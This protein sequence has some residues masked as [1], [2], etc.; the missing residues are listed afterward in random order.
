MKKRTS[1]LLSLLLTL[2]M[3][4]GMLPFMSTPAPALAANMIDCYWRGAKFTNSS[5]AVL[6]DEDGYYLADGISSVDWTFEAEKEHAY[7]HVFASHLS[8]SEYSEN[9]RAYLFANE[10]CTVPFQTVPVS[11]NTYYVRFQ[12]LIHTSDENI[13]LYQRLNDSNTT[14]A[15][16]GCTTTFVNSRHIRHWDIKDVENRVTDIYWVYELTFRVTQGYTLE[17]VTASAAGVLMDTTGKVRLKEYQYDLTWKAGYAPSYVGYVYPYLHTDPE[18]TQ[19]LSKM[20]E[21]DG[22]YYVPLTFYNTQANDTTINF[23]LISQATLNIPDFSVSKKSIRTFRYLSQD[24]VEILFEVQRDPYVIEKVEAN[25]KQ[26]KKD[27]QGKYYFSYCAATLTWKDDNS[28]SY[29]FNGDAYLYRDEECLN[30]PFLMELRPN[31]S[32]YA[33][34]V[35]RNAVAGNHGIDFSQISPD[36]TLS[37]LPGYTATFVKSVPYLGTDGMDAVRVIFRVTRGDEYILRRIDATSTGVKKH[38]DG[39]PYLDGLSYT[40]TWKDNKSPAL[41]GDDYGAPRFYT[42]A[43]CTNQVTTDLTV[44]TNYYVPLTFY[45]PVEYDHS[46]DFSQIGSLSTLTIP[47]C[48]AA[49]YKIIPFVDSEHCDSVKVVFQVTKLPPPAAEYVLEKFDRTS[50]GVISSY[51]KYLVNEGVET[52]TWVND[53]V[54]SSIVKNSTLYLFTD[55]AC[56]TFLNT[57]PVVGQPYYVRFTICNGKKNDHSID[58]S[59]ISS[60]TLTIPLYDVILHSVETYEETNNRDAVRIIF[61][62]TKHPYTLE[63]ITPTATGVAQRNGANYYLSGYST[64][65][66]WKDD[67]APPRDF[68]PLDD[69]N[70]LYIDEDCD[71][72]LTTEPEAGTSY[73][74]RCGVWH[75]NDT[76]YDYSIDMD[77][78]SETT[79]LT[80]PG[81]SVAFHKVGLYEDASSG[82]VERFIIFKV[83]FHALER[84]DVTATGVNYYGGGINAL[85]GCRVKYTWANGALPFGFS[86]DSEIY[87]G[88]FLC[89]D[90]DCTASLE[91]EPLD[92]ETYYWSFR[93][94]ARVDNDHSIDFSRISPDS[95]L[96]VP[97][98]IATFHKSETYVSP[99]S[100]SGMV[101]VIFKLTK[102]GGNPQTGVFVDV[103]EDTYY[104]D[105]VEWA[106]KEGITSGTGNG[107]TFSPD[108]I[109]TRA[110][111][112]TFLW[113]AKGSPEP[114]SSGN[115][116]VD[117]KTGSY[118]H[119]AVLWAVE[120]GITNGTGNGTTFSPDMECTRAQVAT[121]LWRTVGKPDV[122]NKTHPFRDIEAGSYYYDA[123]L[124]A[125]EAGVT[126][127]TGDGTTF[128]PNKSCSRSEIVTFL[129]RALK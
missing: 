108:M 113:R 78:I 106:V 102:D 62:L 47:G 85:D 79:T 3:V 59:Q 88:D 25:A 2:T 81:Y 101:R 13:T 118:Y 82:R 64:S 28:S 48:R 69:D 110:Q 7:G 54:P 109:C 120:Q 53:D 68:Y 73:Y 66:V 129:Y 103:A 9:P 86:S 19:T 128:S 33:S 46:I 121:F 31:E 94:G 5:G 17:E 77:R 74:V 84:I 16:P 67:V 111:V 75:W 95:T 125:V 20:P 38:S 8:V 115:P 91:G 98:Y 65:L 42:D 11:G 36:S 71:T 22:K 26:L 104:F 70:Y 99:Y 112:V 123:V 12:C 4:L 56:T 93:T 37:L 43:D 52:L 92:G 44:G 45:N 76:E 119:K 96:T 87:V 60:A 124:W 32:G 122:G 23:N 29:L 1:K 15:I 40:F 41:F 14:L 50:S 57:K 27:S 83:S 10:G 80:L 30:N 55:A 107:T 117:V 97:G 6:A 39:T 58:F 18:C 89:I 114:Q 72:R 127:G 100:N 116:F 24:R 61:K 90:E 35:I 51:D 63:K 21:P 49:F 34:L 126:N 105:A